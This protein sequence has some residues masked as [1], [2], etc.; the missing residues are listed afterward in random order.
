MMSSTKQLFLHKS[1]VLINFNTL[2]R[3]C[4]LPDKI[5]SKKLAKTE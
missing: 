5:D 1:Y 4:P 2:F 3:E